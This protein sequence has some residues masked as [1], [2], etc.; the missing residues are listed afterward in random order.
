MATPASVLFRGMDQSFMDFWKDVK[1]LAFGE[2]PDYDTMRKRFEDCWRREGFGDL[3][4]RV[5]WW[6]M[7]RLSAND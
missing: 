6:G 5:D 3:P 1:G 7:L 2:V 4:G